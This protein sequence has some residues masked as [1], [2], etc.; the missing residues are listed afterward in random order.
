MF[1]AETCSVIKTLDTSS[2]AM[3]LRA[4]LLLG[5]LHATAALHPHLRAAASPRQQRHAPW[6]VRM[7]E[8]R[9][10]Q[11]S[12]LEATL[13]ELDAAGID[14]EVIGPLRDELTQLKLAQKLAELKAGIQGLKSEPAVAS[15]AASS[16]ATDTPAAMP[17]SPA[18]RAA[19]ARPPPAPAPPP[20]PPPVFPLFPWT[21]ALGVGGQRCAVL[22][23]A[24]DGP[25]IAEAMLDTFEDEAAEFAACGCALVGVRKVERGDAADE[26]KAADYEAR[27]P[28]FNFVRGLDGMDELRRDMGW[29][30]NWLQAERDLYYSP[31]VALLEPDG[32]LRVVVALSGLSPSQV[33]GQVLRELHVAVPSESDVIS[34]AESEANMQVLLCHG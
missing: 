9:G 1:R 33:L 21:S 10:A 5:L 26:R 20:P 4:L 22:F 16:A 11:I 30:M 34:F 27:F 17:M 8:G 28:S 15:P 25:K 7:D 23:Y 24:Y 29:D 13:E 31:T 12:K 19:A 6:A 3:R 18:S 2:A 32:G 14:P